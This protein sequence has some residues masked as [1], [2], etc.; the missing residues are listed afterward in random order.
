MP[1]VHTGGTIMAFRLNDLHLHSRL[2]ACAHDEQLVP[3][4][5]LQVA[6]EHN[7]LQLCLTDHL[8]D[9]AVPGASSWYA[10]QSIEHV[11]QYADLPKSGR[12]PFFF[13]SARNCR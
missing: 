4:H 7:Y 3:D 9:P 10:P 12:L 11:R 8:W 2:S 13:G 5:I 6:E 1:G